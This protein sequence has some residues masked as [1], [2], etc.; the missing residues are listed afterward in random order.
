[1]DSEGNLR[2]WEK[3]Q[4]AET[5][6]WQFLPEKYLSKENPFEY[7]RRKFVH[8]FNL[9]Y[10]YFTSKSVLEVGCGPYGYVFQLD[11]AKSRVG[12]EP[13]EMPGLVR[14][15]WKKYLV[16]GIGENIPFGNNSFDV[17]LTFNTL[18]HLLNPSKV[19]QE[20]YRVLRH[21]GEFFTWL[22]VL[23]E[24]FSLLRPVLNKYDAPHPYHLK[25][26]EI[27]ELLKDSLFYIKDSK[28]DKGTGL[29]NNS[30][31]KIIGNCMMDTLSLRAV[32]KTS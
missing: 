24:Q 9:D 3:A 14:K 27:I 17:V 2:R 4:K 6:F 19:V 13:M 23:R 10:E 32:K 1:M 25:Y 7:G 11:N 22:H 5:D 26:S 30:F 31:K 15:D 12:L 18:D 8:G 28:V 16:R 29:P 21:D 20:I